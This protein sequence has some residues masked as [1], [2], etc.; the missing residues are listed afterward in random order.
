MNKPQQDFRTTFGQLAP[1]AI[2]S[3]NEL[4]VLLST[5]PAAVSQMTYR[6]ELP[7]TAFPKKRRACWFVRDIRNW[8]GG[9]A[10]VI[11]LPADPSFRPS[12]A[13][14]RTGRPRFA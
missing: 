8:L 9:N 4:A 7:Q 5:T 10:S 12:Q 11:R 1:E 13:G 2:I 6:G 14:R 3:R